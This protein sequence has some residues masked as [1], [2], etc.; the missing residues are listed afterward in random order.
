MDDAF[1]FRVIPDFPQYSMNLMGQVRN[2]TTGRILKSKRE[3]TRYVKLRRDGKTYDRAMS[4][5]FEEV[6]PEIFM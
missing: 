1:D 2:D 6:F 3:T 5:L 4:R